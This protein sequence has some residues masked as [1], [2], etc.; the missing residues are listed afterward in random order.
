MFLK[1]YLTVLLVSCIVS[2]LQKCF[3]EPSQ[4]WSSPL[5]KCY[6]KNWL[7]LSCSFFWPAYSFN[8]QT[9]LIYELNRR[10]DSDDI[11]LRLIRLFYDPSYLK[12]IMIITYCYYSK[13]GEH[14]PIDLFSALVFNA[15]PL[16]QSHLISS[17][18]SVASICQ[19]RLGDF[20]E[21]LVH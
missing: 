8:C 20:Q 15:F 4:L 9:H 10:Y 19:A 21:R 2:S 17:Q 5:S 14:V 11:V 3:L 6:L 1:K 18:T 13:E 12:M 16:H 7:W